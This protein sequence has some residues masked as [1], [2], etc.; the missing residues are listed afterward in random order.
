M[1]T[2]PRMSVRSRGHHTNH[3]GGGAHT[4]DVRAVTAENCKSTATVV[5]LTR[6][7]AGKNVVNFIE[8]LRYVGGDVRVF[9]GMAEAH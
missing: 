4:A 5:S 6:T 2:R 3:K 7:L 9:V 8:S 1:G